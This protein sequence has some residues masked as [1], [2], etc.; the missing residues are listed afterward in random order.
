LYIGHFGGI[1][2]AP[3]TVIGSN[4][5]L[6]QSITIGAWGSGEMYGAPVI[7][8]NTYIAPGARLF[9]KIRVGNNVKI[10]ANAV[11]YKDVPNNAIVVLD[12]GFQIISL[13]GNI[14]EVTARSAR[15]AA[16]SANPQRRSGHQK[17][18][19]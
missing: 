1:T 18:K 7:G 12:P 14:P 10:G 9:G 5:T 4:C 13:K 6:G 3:N 16:P 2:V 19:R 11:I 17:K 15:A 8:D